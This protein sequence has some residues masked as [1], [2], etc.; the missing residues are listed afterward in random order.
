MTPPSPQPASSV[1]QLPRVSLRWFVCG[2]AAANQ[3]AG[4]MGIAWPAPA[5]AGG[6]VG[7]AGS[8]PVPGTS[9]GSSVEMIDIA[10]DPAAAE[11][12]RV[13]A[14]PLLEVT[15]RDLN[16]RVVATRRFVGGLANPDRLRQAVDAFRSTAIHTLVPTHPSELS[17]HRNA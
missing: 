13:L 11:A 14:T 10:V 3:A 17:G 12:A 6:E 15:L 4:V 1:G 9:I 5:D 7:G 16:D 2:E 8:E